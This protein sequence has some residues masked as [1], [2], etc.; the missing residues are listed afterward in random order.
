MKK[1]TQECYKQNYFI[2]SF[3]IIWL[4]PMNSN[5]QKFFDKVVVWIFSLVFVE[6]ALLATNF[7]HQ[8]LNI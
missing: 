2:Y 5:D 8:Y 6:L 3:Y 7:P 1:V 4:N